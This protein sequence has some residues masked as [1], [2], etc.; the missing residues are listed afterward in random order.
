MP[1][2]LSHPAPL[3]AL[4]TGFGLTRIPMR[5]LL[6]ALFF[7]IA[8]DFDVLSFRL[9]I[10]YSSLL[11][12]RG[13][14]HSLF[15]AVLAGIFGGLM[16]PRLHCRRWLAFALLFL[17]VASHIILDAATTGGLGVAA[18][19][20]FSAERHF[21]PWR[22]IQ[23]SPLSLRAFLS[24]QGLA[25]L[26]SEFRW[27]WLPSLGLAIFLRF[28]MSAAQ[29]CLSN[30]CKT[31]THRVFCR[32]C[33]FT[34]LSL[35]GISLYLLFAGKIQ[36]D[37]LDE[38]RFKEGDILFQTSISGQGQAIQLATKSKYTHCGIILE[39]AGQLYVYEAINK[40]A[41]TTIQEWIRRGDNE[42][43]V[44]M[45]LKDRDRLLTPA[46]LTALKN[47]GRKLSQKTYDLLFQWNDD[48]I[49]CSE[50]VWKMYYR[51]AG[52]RFAPLRA[53]KDYNLDSEV[54]KM[55]IQ[56]RYGQNFSLEEKAVSPDDLLQSPLLEKIN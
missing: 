24:S 33:L 25:V 26:S 14:S 19:W 52:I 23:V 37:N 32:L 6:L 4:G 38:V 10:P 54:V 29:K 48:K 40:M 39:K 15:F 44:L 13:F 11:G 47:E 34:G 56:K 7:S 55:L 18:F 42:H 20:P 27:V 46:K 22:P 49:Y 9:G 5:L 35:A 17:A 21:L 50:L 16:A 2:I 53:F 1:T 36:A 8:P 43:Y 30:G 51:G 3:L 28:W 45:R 41:W 31:K 12:H